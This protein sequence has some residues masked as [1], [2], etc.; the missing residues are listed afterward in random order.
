MVFTDLQ[1]YQTILNNSVFK[2]LFI[3][4]EVYKD[5][6]TLEVKKGM[7]EQAK[8]FKSERANQY[9]KLVSKLTNACY[10]DKVTLV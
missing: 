5:A 3:L 1:K 6:I 4:K 9:Y 7:E 2:N 8:R 10:T